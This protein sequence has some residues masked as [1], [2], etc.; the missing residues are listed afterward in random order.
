MKVLVTV[1]SRAAAYA[2]NLAVQKIIFGSGMTALVISNEEMDD[3]IK[4]VKSLI[5]YIRYWFI[6]KYVGR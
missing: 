5:R 6:G 4:I 3:I 1:A 2:T